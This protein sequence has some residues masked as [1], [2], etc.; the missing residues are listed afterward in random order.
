MS[1]LPFAI[2]MATPWMGAAAGAQPSPVSIAGLP[3]DATAGRGAALGFLEHE[4]ETLQTDGAIIGPDRTFGTLAAEASGRRAVRL[5]RAGQFV[6]AVLGA[7]ADALTV[8]YAIPDSREGRGLDSTIGVYA[9]GRRIAT[10]PLTSRY[11]WYYGAYPFS[12]DPRQARGHHFYDHVRLRL[13]ATLPAGTRLSLRREPGDRTAWTV[14][15]L[16]DFEHA[17]PPAPAPSDALSVVAFGADSTGRS[18][19]VGAFRAAIARARR[20]GRPVWIPPG[21]Y[22]ID[23]HLIVDRVALIGAGHWHSILRGNGIGIYGRLAPRGS[24]DVTLRDFAIIGEVA[25][26]K[27]RARLAG[28]G[29]ALNRSTISGLWIQHTKVGLWMDGPMDGLVVRDLRIVDQAADGLNFHR[30]VTNSLVENCFVRNVGDDGLA[31]WSHRTPNVGNVFRRNTV[32]AP[33]LA[34]GIAIY[35]GRDIMVSDN[36]VAD[37]V[38]EGG[39]LHLGSRFGATP[40]GGDI[41]FSGNMVVRGG[42]MDPNWRFG[43]GAFWIYALDHPITGARI[44]VRHMTLVDSGYEA[45]QLLG[46]RISGVVIEDVEIRGAGTSALQL[47]APGEALFRNVVASGLGGGGIAE[48]GS[49]FRIIDGGGN[50][51]WETRVPL[52]PRGPRVFSSRMESSGD[53]ENTANKGK[54]DSFPVQ[55]NRERV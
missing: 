53:S 42:V 26:R 16:I 1:R 10:L 48:D 41:I 14:I 17:P 39:G 28:V 33:V 18:S 13:D 38:T 19:A 5:E 46:A 15:D 8:R 54:L 20:S 31:M 45:I 40:P 3:P 9:D 7:P 55:S 32:I 43:V 2:F 11:S 52:P 21:I 47:Q 29:G 49:G 6:E 30:G 35:G 44:Q 24:R 36:L 37:I 51:G 34:N 4:A 22:R 12:N 25:E 27:D 23:R 50:R